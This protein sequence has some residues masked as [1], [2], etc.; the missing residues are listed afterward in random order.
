MRE[1]FPPGA[2]ELRIGLGCMRMSTDESSDEELSLE[3]IAA[4]A[5]AGVTVFDTARGQRRLSAPATSR[6][7]RDDDLA[8]GV[9]LSEVPKRVPG[10][11]ECVAP[12]DDRLDL[13]GLEQLAQDLQVRS[14]RLRDEED[15][16]LAA[17]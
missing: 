17:S 6:S 10:L 8:P 14:V 13:R 16:L 15:S 3:T 5:G 4:A 1:S 2:S 12:V 9:T 11:C 7:H